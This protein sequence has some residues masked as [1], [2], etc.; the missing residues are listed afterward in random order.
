LAANDGSKP[1]RSDRDMAD[2]SKL[3]DEL[4]SLTVLEAAE[5]AKLLKDKWQPSKAKQPTVSVA[6][7]KKA[8]VHNA[9]MT[10]EQFISDLNSLAFFKEFT[11]SRNTFKPAGGGTELELADN[12]VWMGDDVTILQLKERSRNDIKDEDSETRWFEEKVLGNATKQVRDTLKFL[13]AHPAIKVTNERGHSFDIRGEQLRTKT[14]IVV[15]LP[16]KIV[17]S[18]ARATRPAFSWFES[19]QATSA[20]L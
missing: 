8:I 9:N 4:S 14:K 6:N 10:L 12:I 19:Y 5:L 3:V 15:Y 18:V 2:V 16:G 11:F 1:G 20:S 13:E 7:S 17:P